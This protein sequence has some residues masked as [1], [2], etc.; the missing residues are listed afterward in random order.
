MFNKLKQINDLRKQANTIKHAL[1]EEVIEV[2]NRAIKLVVD[3]NQ[4]I[5]NLEIKPEYLHQDKK[6][7]LEKNIKDAF[8]EA[9]KKVQRKMASKMQDMGDFKLPSLK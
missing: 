3:G 9:L 5:K 8:S 2:E 6:S 1:A 7:D 4:D